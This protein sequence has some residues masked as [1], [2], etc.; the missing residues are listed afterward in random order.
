M[1]RNFQVNTINIYTAPPADKIT[2]LIGLVHFMIIDSGVDF[3]LLQ[4]PD[5]MFYL[6]FMWWTTVQCTSL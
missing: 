6:H 2:G 5:A 1:G 4:L 3:T